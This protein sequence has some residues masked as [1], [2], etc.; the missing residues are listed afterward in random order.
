[1]VNRRISPEADDRQEVNPSAPPEAPQE[2]RAWESSIDKHGVE[3]NG[4]TYIPLS[5]A[6]NKI[7]EVQ[8]D[9]AAMKVEHIG[10]VEELERH[11]KEI[12]RDLQSYF[13]GYIKKLNAA[14]EQKERDHLDLVDKISQEAD[15]YREVAEREVAQLEDEVQ[16]SHEEIAKR[17]AQI[18]DLQKQLAI[19]NEDFDRLGH[20]DHVQIAG[21]QDT[22]KKREEEIA[23]LQSTCSSMIRSILV[24]MESNF[25]DLP[26]VFAEME[27]RGRHEEGLKERSSQLNLE[28]EQRKIELTDLM[29]ERDVKV[30]DCEKLQASLDSDSRVFHERIEEKDAVLAKLNEE[31]EEARAICLNLV[32][33][34]SSIQAE[35][36]EAGASVREL[37][38][39]HAHILSISEDTLTRISQ[40]ESWIQDEPRRV[41]AAVLETLLPLDTFL[42]TASKQLGLSAREEGEAVEA[43]GGA[44]E[45]TLDP[46]SLAALLT[47]MENWVDSEK[48]KEE[49]SAGEG[50]QRPHGVIAYTQSSSGLFPCSF[51]VC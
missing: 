3:A 26:V 35:A 23:R 39:E 9:M 14:A 45:R 50:P 34:I 1:M 51:V 42:T 5:V 30:A 19:L 25:K 49:E 38:E 29:M 2:R 18:A 20:D 11:Y 10:I 41:D 36:R 43:E 31:A 44:Q 33:T 17:D 21:L 37:V 12:E 15:V 7:A 46:S 8:A 47:F 40:L 48:E 6:R 16:R 4:Q 13:L 32:H 27:E 28:L 22:I 24:E